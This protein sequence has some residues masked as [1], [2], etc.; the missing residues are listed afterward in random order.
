[1]KFV[2]SDV[3]V[4]YSSEP[5][6]V[7]LVSGRLPEKSVDGG[8]LHYFAAAPPDHRQSFS[9]S[10]MPFAQADQAFYDTPNVGVVKISSEGRFSIQLA[11]PNAYYV[12]LGTQY[13]PPT[14]HIWYTSSGRR[15]DSTVRINAGI[16]FRMLTY[17]TLPTRPRSGPMFY[18]KAPT[19]ARSQEQILRD[20]AYPPL[21][22][23]KMPSNF[24]GLKPPV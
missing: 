11:L 15:K 4:A 9:G 21:G 23:F 7:V 1:M 24:W 3:K 18:L 17:P 20:S 19:F 14:V 13:V 12:G 8:V 6:S 16:P 22:T 5:G 10:G 2:A